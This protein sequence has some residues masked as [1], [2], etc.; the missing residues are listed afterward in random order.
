MMPAAINERVLPRTA[1]KALYP[2]KTSNGDI[3]LFAMAWQIIARL[4]SSILSKPI[5]VDWAAVSK[6]PAIIVVEA[7]TISGADSGLRKI[8][9]A[10]KF[11][12]KSE[13]SDKAVPVM[14]SKIRPAEIMSCISS[15]LFSALEYATYLVMAEFTPQSL[16]RII[17]YDGIKAIEYNPYSSGS[18][19]LA[20]IIVPTAIIMVDAA[21]PMKS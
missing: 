15:P 4:L 5:N 8:V 12:R 6:D 20:K 2:R 16:K 7:M 21:T 18:M 9:D 11:A 13:R 17:I 19:S 10:M 3:A 1:P 14:L